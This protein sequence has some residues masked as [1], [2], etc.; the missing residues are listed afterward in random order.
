MK[1]SLL[2]LALTFISLNSFAEIPTDYE[3]I[4]RLFK[5]LPETHSLRTFS[6]A[7]GR[8]LPQK[9]KALVW[10]IKKAERS[11][12]KQEFN[13]YAEGG[14]LFLLQEVYERPVFLDTISGL[15]EHQWEMG[16][17]F[18]Y[19]QY[20]NAATGSMIGADALPLES[21]VKH[22]PDREP[23]TLTPKATTFAKYDIEGHEADLLVISVHGINFESNGAFR[24]QMRQIE[25]EIRKHGGPVFLAGDFNTWNE[26]RTTF[27]FVVARRLDLT[28]ATYINGHERMTF[29]GWPLDHVFTRGLSVSSATVDGAAL[30]SDHRP[31]LV[32]F[33]VA[34]KLRLRR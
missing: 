7:P 22:S 21:Y 19:R 34:P 16:I 25:S 6:S 9:M 13:R 8:T 10:N 18:F 14:N 23:I 24:R 1:H 5:V 26:A 28:E 31:I 30:G 29:N 3:F 33:E 11:V 4:S 12:W 27:L 17:S 32:N 2:A 20:A 15:A